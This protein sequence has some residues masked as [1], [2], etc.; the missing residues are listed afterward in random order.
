[1]RVLAGDIGG[2]NARLAIVAVD[3]GRARIEREQRSASQEAPGLA[4]IV[5]RFL[6]NSDPSL[7]WACF[8]IPGRAVD[9]VWRTPNLP[10]T[11]DEREL[12]A[13]IGIAPTSF[14]HDFAA[15][16]HGLG[17][18]G[19]KDVE[20]LQTREADRSWSGRADRRGHRAR[21]SVAVL[22]G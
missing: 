13:A 2:T 4:P 16:G 12:A 8:G 22:G 17:Q 20:T 3:G 15:V 5:Q 19:P 9:G 6:G 18:I 14:I 1:M 21:G 11:I 10:W 7:D